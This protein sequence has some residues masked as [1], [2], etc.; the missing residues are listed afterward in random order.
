ML[1][2]FCEEYLAPGLEGRGDDEAVEPGEAIALHDVE[3][4]VNRLA[5]IIVPANRFPSASR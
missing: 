2:V 1:Q 5:M 3:T 4:T